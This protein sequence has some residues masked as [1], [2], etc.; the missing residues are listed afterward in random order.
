MTN[1]RGYRTPDELAL[2][3]V[4]EWI[5]RLGQ[6][7]AV[8]VNDLEV[9]VNTSAAAAANATALGTNNAAR[10]GSLEVLADLAPGDLTDATMASV[11]AQPTSDFRKQLGGTIATASR[12]RLAPLSLLRGLV[13]KAATQPVALVFA[14]DSY[15][16]GHTTALDKRWVTLLATAHSAQAAGTRTTPTPL[17]NGVTIIN[18]AN[19]GMTSDTYLTPAKAAEVAL[20]SPA[21]I[22]HGIGA[23]DWGFSRPA[24]AFGNYVKAVIADLD[25][26]ITAPHVHL[27]LVG[28]ERWDVNK[29]TLPSTWEEYATELRNISDAS[30]ARVAFLDLREVFEPLGIP[31]PDYLD[32]A[33]ADLLHMNDAG[34]QQYFKTLSAVLQLPLIPP[35]APAVVYASDAFTRADS[36]SLGSTTVG[37][38]TW[39]TV[40]VKTFQQPSWSISG[41]ALRATYVSGTTEGLAYVNTAQANGR[42]SVRMSSGSDFGLAFR[43]TDGNNFWMLWNGSAVG[44]TYRL[45]K[46]EAGA[47]TVMATSSVQSAV[48]DLVSVVLSGNVITAY[49]NG[50]LVATVTNSFN[51]TATIHGPR[52]ALTSGNNTIT[53]DDFAHTEA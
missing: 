2:P 15:V 4:V 35:P 19:N 34:H 30:P 45:M 50:V 36:G 17:P 32:Y 3:D 37:A 8:D 48:G 20:F 14:G 7:V 52:A 28:H 42:V 46:F 6:D 53:F 26:R 47:Y 24:A 41:S 18:A 39:T 10:L 38:K 9:R 11:A 16:Y 44:G 29:A 40:A 27:L 12:D 31:G 21:I 51:A 49:A 23:N 1:A 43:I 13:A 33:M 5:D 25:A 22:V